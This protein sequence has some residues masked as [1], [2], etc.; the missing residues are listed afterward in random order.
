VFLNKLNIGHEQTMPAPMLPH[1]LWTNGMAT[2]AFKPP[3]DCSNPCSAPLP[4]LL[5]ASTL[6]Y[7]HEAS[8]EAPRGS[9]AHVQATSN[10]QVGA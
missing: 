2:P 4:S 5:S 7:E 6:P 9:G 3:P 10:L 1:N 8:A